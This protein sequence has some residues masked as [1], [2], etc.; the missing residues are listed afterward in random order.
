MTA[1]MVIGSVLAVSAQS[2]ETL[3]KPESRVEKTVVDATLIKAPDTKKSVANASDKPVTV[4]KATANE[5]GQLKAV[6]VD[7][8]AQVEEKMSTQVAE[9]KTVKVVKTETKVAPANVQK[10]GMTDKRVKENKPKS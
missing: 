2:P 5:S 1:G 8:A 7:K 9:R 3:S 6:P 10:I 4:K